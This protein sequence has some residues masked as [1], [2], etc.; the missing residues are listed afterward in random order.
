MTLHGNEL[1]KHL[2]EDPFEN[3]EEVYEHEDFQVKACEIELHTDISTAKKLKYNDKIKLTKN[4]I[5]IEGYIRGQK[6]NPLKNTCTIRVQNSN[7]KAK[8]EI[9]SMTG[10]PESYL[11]IFSQMWRKPQEILP[12]LLNRDKELQQIFSIIDVQLGEYPIEDQ[13][14]IFRARG[15]M[16]ANVDP[17][18]KLQISLYEEAIISPLRDWLIQL[19]YNN[20]STKYLYRRRENQIFPVDYSPD[21]PDSDRWL[22]SSIEE[23]TG[24]FFQHYLPRILY[25]H[26]PQIIIDM[27]DIKNI[28][29]LST[30]CLIKDQNNCIAIMENIQTNEDED[31]DEKGEI[32]FHV[33]LIKNYATMKLDKLCCY[34]KE[35]PFSNIIS[36]LCFLYDSYF[37]VRNFD[38][39]YIRPNN[40]GINTIDIRN[41]IRNI[42]DYNQEVSEY[43]FP[44]Y[45]FKA[46]DTNG[47]NAFGLPPEVEELLNNTY[48]SKVKGILKTVLK[49]Y[50]GDFPIVHINDQIVDRNYNF[51]IVKK[52]EYQKEGKV[53][54][55]TIH[56]RLDTIENFNDWWEI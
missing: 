12:L 48:S 45:S 35:Q 21:P 13:S 19:T 34:W 27:F 54:V 36:D 18:E 28:K 15:C 29:N 50:R 1:L 44:E 16:R 49:I 46:I 11:H 52:I 30:A 31:E 38:Q 32:F 55:L 7:I 2:I 20:K 42:I 41:Y 43:S 39:L 4:G 24:T 25:E 22:K 51:G 3:Y 53:Y 40:I 5:T 26:I 6:R 47:G 9:H 23:V 10:L 56:K 37:Q 33:F 17:K 8:T 14:E